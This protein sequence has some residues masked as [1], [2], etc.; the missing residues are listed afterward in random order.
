MVDM[1][2]PSIPIWE[3]CCPAIS[4]AIGRFQGRWRASSTDKHS[5]RLL[6]E[7]IDPVVTAYAATLPLRYLGH[8]PGVGPDVKPLS[9]IAR[10]IGFNAMARL[11]RQL[12]RAFTLT[13][14]R[15][16]AR[17]KQFVATLETLIELVS[18]CARKRPTK[19]KIRDTN[20]KSGRTRGFC[21]FCGAMAELT[22]F[23]NGSEAPK[24]NDPE[25]I[26]RLSNL[27]CP[28][29]RPRLPTGEWNPAYRRA[30]RSLAQFDQELARLGL[31]STKMQAGQAQSGDALIDS[32]VFH[33]VRKYGFQPADEAELRHHARW[34]VD[35][36]VTDRKKQMV[37][38][39]RYGMSQSDIARKLSIKRQAVFKAL[40]SIPED[41]RQL[42][43]LPG[44]P[45]HFL[46]STKSY[47]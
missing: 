42:P 12:L 43:I 20:L 47:N 3:G 11:Q 17:E 45:S 14:N 4:E 39:H 31:Q 29:H 5:V 15:W 34:M 10:L 35:N 18:A 41:A 19:S 36:K 26:L 2:N 37:I 9:E 44:F 25:D 7:L 6:K 27:Y 38:L 46:S 30:K 1:R 8:V 16:S 40:A 33:Y 28:E 23:G 13:N 21:R 22:L 24:A 32:Y